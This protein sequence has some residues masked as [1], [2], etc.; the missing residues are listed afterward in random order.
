MAEHTDAASHMALDELIA[1]ADLPSGMA[2]HARIVGSEPVLPTRYRVGT[3]GAAALAATGLAAAELWRLR[4]SRQQT[5]EVKMRP[6]TISLRSGRY[7]RINGKPPGR[8]WDPLSG[9]YP[10]RDGR[11]VMLHTNF[12]NLRDAAARVLGTQVDR[13]AVTK[14]VA[15]WDAEALE[16]A[17]HENGACGAFARTHAEWAAHPHAAAIRD[18]PVVEIIRIGDAPPQSVAGRPAPAVRR[19]RAGPDPRHRRADLRA[20]PGGTRRRRVEDHP[21]RPAAFRRSRSGDRDRQT[22]RASRSA[23]SGAGRNAARADPHADVFSQSYRPGALA[24][25][26]FSPE[27]VAALRPGIVCVTLSA[28]SHAGPWRNRRGYDTIVQTSTGMADAS[29]VEGKPQHLPVSAIDYVSGN[30]MAFGAMVALARRATIGGSW[31]V[32]VSLATTGRWIVD[33]RHLRAGAARRPRRGSA[34][35]RDR[36]ALHRGR[37]TGR[38]H[39]LPGADR[40]HERDAAALGPPAGA[41]RVSPGGV[42]GRMTKPFAGVRVLDLTNVIAGPVRVLSARADGRRGNQ[43]RGAGR[44]RSGAQDGRRPGAGKAP[45][46]RVLPGDECRQEVDHAQSEDRPAARRSF[47]NWSQRPTWCWRISAP[48]PWRGSA[49]PRRRCGHGTLG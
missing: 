8:D 4:T 10:T 26:G 33:R 28:W 46:G 9:F 6:A 23:R 1:L 38:A 30:L 47:A 5:V 37:C 29:A 40:A 45:D 12:A 22:V 16:T 27:A 11:F 41:A 14:A 44:R 2:A 18:L 21:G 35:R 20:H 25:R 43:D 15:G 39:P 7:M 3:A 48:V 34:G 49:W 31:L 42:A 36:A 32:R 17:L 24:A 13:D 19:A